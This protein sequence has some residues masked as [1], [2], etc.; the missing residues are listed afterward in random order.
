MELL[1]K[2][3]TEH[4]TDIYGENDEKFVEAYGRKFFLLY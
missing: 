3:F 1:L 2:K 4:F